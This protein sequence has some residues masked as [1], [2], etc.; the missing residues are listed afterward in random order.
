MKI[1]VATRRGGSD[2]G[3]PDD[4]GVVYHHRQPRSSDPRDFRSEQTS[5]EVS[6][7]DRGEL[8]KCGHAVDRF[9]SL[10]SR[11]LVAL[12]CI[13]DELVQLERIHPD[14]G[15]HHCWFLHSQP[16]DKASIS[17]RQRADPGC[18]SWGWSGRVDYA[19]D[20]QAQRGCGAGGNMERRDPQ[21]QRDSDI[22]ARTNPSPDGQGDG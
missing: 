22:T 16:Q 15:A 18:V 20:Q 11:Y 2:G 14:A 3:S 4:L 21:H 6:Q 1:P 5:R 19:N 10:A 9:P 17:N 8:E 12:A 7:R 13:L